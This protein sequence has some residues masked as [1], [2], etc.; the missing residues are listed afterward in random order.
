VIFP[1]FAAA[2]N[3]NGSLSPMTCGKNFA[4]AIVETR[5]TEEMLSGGCGR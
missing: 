4:L 1:G 3:V 2:R 5:L